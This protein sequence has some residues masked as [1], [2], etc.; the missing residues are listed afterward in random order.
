MPFLRKIAR[1]YHQRRKCIQALA[2]NEK[3]VVE[4]LWSGGTVIMPVGALCD[5]RADGTG[6]RRPWRCCTRENGGRETLFRP[7]Q[8][9]Q[10]P[11]KTTKRKRDYISTEVADYLVLVIRGRGVNTCFRQRCHDFSTHGS[12]FGQLVLSMM[13]LQLLC[14]CIEQ[15]ML[16][17]HLPPKWRSLFYIRT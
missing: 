3:K 7:W 4:S 17:K 1:H 6:Q 16:P 11:L 8:T 2:K 5:I 12:N 10:T 9:C 13:L 14:T 15:E